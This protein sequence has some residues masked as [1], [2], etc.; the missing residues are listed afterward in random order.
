MRIIQG[1]SAID[2][3]KML[4]GIKVDPCGINIMQPK[5]SFYLVK[6]SSLACIAANILKQEMLSLGGDAA[7]ARDTIS[8]KI[9]TTD[10]LLMANLAQ[11][12]RLNQKLKHQPF[13]LNKIAKDLALALE[14]YRKDRFILDLGKH[15][16]SLSLRTHIMGIV[17]ITTDSFSGDGLYS[18]VKN[19]C[20]PARQKEAILKSILE[21]AQKLA[22]D[23]ADIIDIGGE[24]SR[25]G[26]KQISCKEELAR[27]I[28][29]I[30]KLVKNIRLPI[31]I[32]TYKPEVAEQALDNGA[33]IINDI[34]GL[35]NKKMLK[36]AVKYNAAVIVMHMQGTPRTMQTKPYYVS[37]IDD[38][39]DFLSSAVS[40]ALEAGINRDKIII[41]PGIGFGKTL[42]HNLE[43]LKRLSDFKILGLPVL[44]G[45]SRKS[46]IG[47]ILGTQPKDRLFGTISSCILASINGANILRVHDVREVRDA[48]RLSDRI[49][50]Q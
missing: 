44:V 37:L 30:R 9:K 18:I 39:I 47:K 4:Q 23:G 40:R 21:Y 50:K 5:A 49:L 42:E 28:P 41:D 17:N 19:P 11:L 36:V 3:K 35:K 38:I 1:C 31:S 22:K 14:N 8:A 25:P 16:L 20:Q 34:T 6:L 10:C 27:V 45:A 13:G 32:D 26:A 7:V 29:A 43:I 2:L 24:S 33:V 48:L 12:K 15:K 46:F